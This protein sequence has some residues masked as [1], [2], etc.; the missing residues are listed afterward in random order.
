MII[1]ATPTAI[2]WAVIKVVT[3]FDAGT[4][5]C[6]FNELNVMVVAT[7]KALRNGMWEIE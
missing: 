3:T 6:R 2:Y 5:A 1:N 7:T 4:V